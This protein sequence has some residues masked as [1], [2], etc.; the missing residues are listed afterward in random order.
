MHFK[1]SEL[2][3]DPENP[4][5]FDAFDRKEIVEATTRLISSLTGPFVIAVDSEWGTGKTTFIRMLKACLEAEK[6][7]CLYFNAWETDFAEDP[8]I[9]FVGELDGL[10]EKVC[11]EEAERQK[12]IDKT[13]E[14]TGAVAKRAVPAL[15]KIATFGAIDLQ[16]D[17]EKILAELTGNMST[18]A[19]AHYLQEKKCIAEFHTELA[20]VLEAVKTFDKNIPVVI[21]VDELDRCRPLYAIEL[22][23]R[24]KHL[25][26]VE[27]AVFVVAVDKEQLGI[28][29]GAVYGHGFN[30]TEYLRR[31]FDLE[32]K[33]SA[34]HG[35]KYYSNLIQRMGIEELLQARPDQT[36]R[37]DIE[38]L[39]ISFR[40]LSKALA[41]T[42]RAQEQ[43]MGLLKLALIATPETQ[44]LFPVETA[45]LAALKIANATLYHAISRQGKSVSEA[46]QYLN[47]KR[48]NAQK[49]EQRE[50]QHYWAVIQGY[51]LSLRRQNDS[52]A[53]SLIAAH[54][55][56]TR[57]PSKPTEVQEE[58]RIVSRIINQGVGLSTASL[59]LIGRR[60]DVAA[61]FSK[62]W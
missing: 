6:H 4:F 14:I 9:A 49:R 2:V 16:Q 59:E 20:R 32:L 27:Q 10:M 15:V 42:P 62:E 21:F 61:Q 1:P 43:Y 47:E 36:R 46:I 35:E 48:N 12:L 55:N 7:P 58:G 18:D 54:G 24:I 45:I 40:F 11:P 33:L 56:N 23:E 44:R 30:A 57:D 53:N 26:N 39:K 31:F 19:V 52:Q 41:L 28:S 5:A 37:A 8:L 17:T 25:F 38:E 13:K 29:L 51:L 34:V 3:V 60:I 22:L 50:E